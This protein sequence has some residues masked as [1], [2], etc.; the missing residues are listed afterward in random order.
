MTI[1]EASLIVVDDIISLYSPASPYGC[2]GIE[3]LLQT[4]IY[5]L[6]RSV[7]WV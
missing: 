5:M 4:Y 6:S 2:T 7:T 1:P 3:E